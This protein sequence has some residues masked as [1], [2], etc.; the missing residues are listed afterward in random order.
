MQSVPRFSVI[1]NHQRPIPNLNPIRASPTS[2]P[3]N[4]V[5]TD[6]A[7]DVSEEML[8]AQIKINS[9]M[10]KRVDDSEAK[11]KALAEQIKELQGTADKFK[12]DAEYY[13]QKFKSA[14]AECNDL[15]SK[16]KKGN[17]AENKENV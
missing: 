1:D 5:S 10:M 2:S 9:D 12:K 4:N 13:M 8:Q 17:T 16:G 14:M 7:D 15:K 6:T 11:N 3:V